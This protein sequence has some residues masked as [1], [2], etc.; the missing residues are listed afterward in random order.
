MLWRFLEKWPL[1][2]KKYYIWFYKHGRALNAKRLSYAPSLN[3]SPQYVGWCLRQLSLKKRKPDWQKQITI[4]RS[5]KVSP[6]PGSHLC[7]LLP[8]R[9]RMGHC[10]STLLIP[11]WSESFLAPS[12]LQSDI[13][14]KS[15]SISLS[16]SLP[17]VQ[18]KLMC[19]FLK[20]FHPLSFTTKLKRV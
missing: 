16:F 15:N 5:L 2:V 3:T 12:L 18:K 7:F 17:E 9:G 4:P 8:L 11:W 20:R 6:V 1:N 19:G 14:L 10:H 13:P